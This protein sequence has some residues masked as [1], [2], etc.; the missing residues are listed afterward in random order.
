LISLAMPTYETFGRGCEFLEFQFQILMKQTF[1]DFEV[2]I[3]D[4]SKN[5]E[6]KNLCERYS[7]KLKIVY[8]HNPLNRGSLSHNTNN[9][10]KNCSGNIIKILFQDDFLYGEDSLQKIYNSFT[11]AIQWVIGSCEHISDSSNGLFNKVVPRYSDEIMSGVNTIGNPSVVAFRNVEDN[12]LFDEKMTWTVDLDYYKRMHDKN[13]DP[14]VIN[15]TI[16]IIR[17]WDK[18]LTNLI[19]SKIKKREERLIRD[20]YAKS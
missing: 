8:I 11:P 4:H 20:R 6:I 3:S 5:E 12:V 9:A 1:K 13:G 18:Q 7:D 17:I 16:V 2:V 15:D 14:A 10:I 19:P